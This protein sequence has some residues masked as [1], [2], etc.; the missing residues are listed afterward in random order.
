MTEI[1]AIV[2]LNKGD[3]IRVNRDKIYFVREHDVIYV[4]K[5]PFTDGD[6]TYDWPHVKEVLNFTIKEYHKKVSL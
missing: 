5:L 6:K 1:T 2:K 3:L 4:N